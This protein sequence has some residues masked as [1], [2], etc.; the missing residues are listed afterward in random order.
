MN[1]S[2]LY[3]CAGTYLYNV[4]KQKKIETKDKERKVEAN[5]STNTGKKFNPNAG[6]KAN[7]SDIDICN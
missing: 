2:N 6:S 5:E 3:D 7:H 4:P 1:V